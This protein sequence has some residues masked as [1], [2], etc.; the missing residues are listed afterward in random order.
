MAAPASTAEAVEMVLAGL[1]YLAAADP[2]TMAAQ[3]QAGFLLALEQGDV[4]LP[5]PDPG[6]SAGTGLRVNLTA[7]GWSRSVS[8]TAR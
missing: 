3:A 8:D 1:S 7:Q 2:A 6:R 5:V 4:R